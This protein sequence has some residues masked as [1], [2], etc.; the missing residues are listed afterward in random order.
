MPAKFF[1]HFFACDRDDSY[2]YPKPI[3]I[4]LGWIEVA[5]DL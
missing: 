4:D 1:L 2:V 5:F 3:L